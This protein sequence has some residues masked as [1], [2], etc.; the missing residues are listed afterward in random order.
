MKLRYK[1]TG[2]ILAIVA[3]AVVSL[4]LVISHD[5]PCG[6]APPLAADARPMKAIIYRCYGSPEV[7]RLE[8]VAKP[9]PGDKDVL[10][11]V[12]AASLNPYDWHFMRG[13][14]YVMRMD[15]GIG[16]PKDTRFGVDYSGTV[17]AV[18][19]SVTRYHVGD[20]V[21]GARSGA[22]SEYLI[23]PEDRVIVP[24]P[25]GIS[26]DQAASIPMASMTALQA[27]RENGHVKA[28]QKVL[29]NGASGGV[30]TFA[31]QLARVMGADV[32]AVASTRNLEMVRGLGANRVID[33]TKEDFTEG[34]QKYDLILDIAG[35]HSLSD[36]RRVLTHEGTL[37]I[38]GATDRGN[39]FGP[40]SEPVKALVMSPFVSQNMAMMLATYSQKDLAYVADL[41]STGKI[42][43]VID[44]RYKLS[45]VP[46]AIAYLEEGH[47]RGKVIINV[48]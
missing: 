45:E 10:V 5:S 48:E 3:V 25:A 34:T 27:L 35:T 42:T 23:V 18:G 11:K 43:A 2:A 46:A 47:A 41:M 30:G 8:D 19:R 44:R 20:E 33:Y 37:V 38:V 40:L 14:P 21:F 22:L 9:T 26:F 13:S 1:I 32:T 15:S 6:T 39:W 12:H 36:Y 17:E 29:I 16:A 24:K 31:V 28:G 4:C 7:L